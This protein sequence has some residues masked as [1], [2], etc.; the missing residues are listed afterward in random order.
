MYMSENYLEPLKRAR[1]VSGLT[2]K[3]VEDRLGMRRLMMR[4]HEIGRLKLPISIAIDLANLYKISIDELIG[5]FESQKKK[6]QSKALIN[7]TSLFIQ[8]GQSIMY[9]DPILRAFLE[10]HQDK[11]FELSLFELITIDLNQKQKKESIYEIGR[12]LFL[13]A[14][15]DGRISDEE[16]ECIKNLLNQF[17]LS[18]SYKELSRLDAKDQSSKIMEKIELRHFTI[19]ILYFFSL[20][21]K[22]ISYQEIDFIDKYAEKLKI[23]KSNYLFIKSKFVKENS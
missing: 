22:L 13:L 6:A 4:D 1:E 7:F 19:W 23:N 12:L 8:N 10:D 21:D 5:N 3:D 15:C 20:A 11:Y 16:I 9:L 17:G 2:Q 18:S 14:S